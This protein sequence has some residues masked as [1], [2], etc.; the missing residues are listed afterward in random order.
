MELIS[1]IV[2]CLFIQRTADDSVSRMSLTGLDKLP[3]L[4][5]LRVFVGRTVRFFVAFMFGIRCSDEFTDLLFGN[6]RHPGTAVYLLEV[7]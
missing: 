4:L 5:H 3:A 6:P 7:D 2:A 1:N